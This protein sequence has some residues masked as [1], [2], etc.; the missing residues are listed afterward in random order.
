[1]GYSTEFLGKFIISPAL[2]NDHI[3]FLQD[4]AGTL[5]SQDSEPGQWCQWVPSED[6]VYLEWDYGEKF[7]DYVEWLNY[8]VEKFL[9]PWGYKLNGTVEC[10]GD[11]YNDRS[12]IV[13][14]DNEV[15]V[16]KGKIVYE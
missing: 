1:M 6:G 9:I 12:L 11:R 2:K 7:Y 5:H 8:I 3:N 16:K 15:V 13:V 14:V 10:I 4:F